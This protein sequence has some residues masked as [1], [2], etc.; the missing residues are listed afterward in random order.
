MTGIEDADEEW[1]FEDDN[2]F[3]YPWDPVGKVINDLRTYHYGPSESGDSDADKWLSVG[4]MTI[5]P[6]A[7]EYDSNWKTHEIRHKYDWSKYD[8]NEQDVTDWEPSQNKTGSWDVSLNVGTGA[9]VT[10]DYEQPNI[11]MYQIV[12]SNNVDIYWDWTNEKGN[13]SDSVISGSSIGSECRVE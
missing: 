6:G 1:N 5:H 2:Y 8:G 13:N 10:L 4:E 7:A 12:D 11:D 9:M 3:S